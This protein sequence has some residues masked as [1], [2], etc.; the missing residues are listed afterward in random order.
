MAGFGPYHDGIFTQSNY[1]IVTKLGYWLLPDLGGYQHY[2]VAFQKDEDL[3]KAI[4]I[5]RPLRLAGLLQNAPSI[6]NCTLDL[7][8]EGD[9]T[10]YSSSGKPLTE[11][12]LQAAVDSREIGRW[13]FYGAIYGPPPVREIFWQAI[14]GAFSQVEGQYHATTLQAA[15]LSN[16]QPG[17]K[18]FLPQDVPKSTTSQPKVIHIRE[19][20]LAGIPSTHE[21]NWTN[22]VPNGSTFFFSPIS[23]VNG[24]DTTKQYNIAL[25][26]F[27]E[28]GFDYLGTFTIGMRELHH[29]VIVVFNREDAEEKKRAI[30]MMRVLVDDCAAEG[31]G[32]YR[33]HLALM[34]QI[35]GT[36]SWNGGSMMGLNETIKDALDPN[37]ILAPGKSGVW[38]R[39]Y[40][41]GKMKYGTGLY[42]P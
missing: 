26:R 23:P 9:R 31:Y 40:R 25:R 21:L 24:T 39:K 34:D 27:K 37:G 29:I 20:T 22:F 7:A 35:A 19:D 18:F 38:G 6:R 16:I 28:Y 42:L 8:V 14:K 1:G 15:A 3:P 11:E 33:T 5:I 4:D 2:M 13:T 17:A 30:E 36:Y 32:E 12:E 41:E 10:K